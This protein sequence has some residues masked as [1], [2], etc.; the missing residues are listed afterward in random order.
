MNETSMNSEEVNTVD[1]NNEVV[2]NV[3]KESMNDKFMNNEKADTSNN[4]RNRVISSNDYEIREASEICELSIVLASEKSSYDIYIALHH[5]RIYL[6]LISAYQRKAMLGNHQYYI[7][8]QQRLE[9]YCL[10]K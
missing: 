10:L 6:M 4:E 9:N 8:N 7:A 5:Q 3:W 1:Q 2:Q